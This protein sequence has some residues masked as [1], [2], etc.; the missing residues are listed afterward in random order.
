[1]AGLHSQYNGPTSGAALGRRSLLS[2][3]PGK[4]HLSIDFDLVGWRITSST[5]FRYGVRNRSHVYLG[6]HGA[7]GQTRINSLPER[8]QQFS[9]GLNALSEW[10]HVRCTKTLARHG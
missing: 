4:Q 10:D 8:T 1:M 5:E 2:V 7:A 9:P 3:V 6:K